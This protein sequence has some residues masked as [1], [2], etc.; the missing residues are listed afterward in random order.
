MSNTPPELTKLDPANKEDSNRADLLRHL[1]F[2]D[3][4]GELDGA[5]ATDIVSNIVAFGFFM[6]ATTCSQAY[7]INQELDFEC[8]D[9]AKGDAVRLNAN[10]TYC[11]AQVEAAI[12]DRLRLETKA[13]ERNPAYQAQTPD[14]AL[15]SDLK[16]T[17]AD[18]SDG[19][20]KYVCLQC[21][22]RDVSQTI[23]MQMTV[24]C[25]VNT[26]PFQTAFING[27]SLAAEQSVTQYQSKL[28][29]MGAS[30]ATSTDIKRASIHISDTIR[31][32]SKVE[33][34][35]YLKQSALIAQELKIDKGSTS[36]VIQNVKQAISLTMLSSIASKVYTDSKVKTAIGY[37]AAESALETNYSLRDAYSQLL[38]SVDTM[39][40]A[41]SNTVVRI[42]MV[43][44]IILVI[45]VLIFASL[46]FF[47][48]DILFG[49]LT[50]FQGT[51]DK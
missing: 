48:P 21:V 3:Q 50:S 47:K 41:L 4:K 26:Q 35:N 10:C 46:F 23:Q 16:G 28:Q 20:C 40:Q 12:A 2:F 49:G 5:S 8:N 15:L 18:S 7:E 17:L 36:V 51:V 42:V 13:V 9:T 33:V 39:E 32:I 6:G 1:Y 37:E 43:I 14:P 29:D 38:Q 22:A 44:V 34:L 45:A 25:D 27:M 19:A 31:N 30:V 24:Q 11:K